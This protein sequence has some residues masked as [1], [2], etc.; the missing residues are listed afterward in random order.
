[1]RFLTKMRPHQ[2][3]I[4][5]VFVFLSCSQEYGK[6]SYSAAPKVINVSEYDPK[7]RQRNGS[8]YTPL[9]QSALKKNGALGLIARCG[10][11]DHI[12][13]KCADFL[14]GAERQG[15]LLGTYYYLLPDSNP[16]A[17]AD[18]YIARLRQIKRSRNL[19]TRK[20]LLAA[21][22]HT[23]CQAWQIVAYLKRIKQL[24]GVT[25]VVYLE[26]SDSIRRTLNNASASQKR[27]LRQHPYWLALYSSGYSGLETPQKL[28]N[29]SGVWGSWAMW[30]YGGVW[31]ENG[32][33]K[34]HH[35]R[36]GS[37]RTPKYFGNL[38]QPTERNGFN[39]SKAALYR[40]WN[41]HSWAW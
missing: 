24:T 22:I 35:Y 34:P 20:I 31:W 21:D 23:Q 2:L 9:N 14:V 29:A 12:D 6:V 26:N 11:G 18:K 32:G 27:F 39:G 8:S 13:N 36:G 30:Q 17:L 40:F 33:S 19:Q 16:T 37:W 25:P 10:K 41:R 28:A 15:M 4:P 7:E 3:L 38:S 1:M 5:F